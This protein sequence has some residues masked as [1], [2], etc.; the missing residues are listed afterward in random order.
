M[1]RYPIRRTAGPRISG[2]VTALGLLLGSLGGIP[3]AAQQV[4]RS[5]EPGSD[6]GSGRPPALA[7]VP[8][9]AGPRVV[10]WWEAAA[11]VGGVGA[12]MT[13]DR[14]VAHDA[15]EHPTAAA[16]DVADAFRQAGNIKVYA[17]VTLGTLGAGLLAHDQGISRTG[18]QLAASGAVAAASVELLKEATGRS[19]PDAGDGAYEFRP[20][21]GG[22]SF[23]SGHSAAAFALA[24]TIGDASHSIWVQAGLYAVATGTAWSRVYDERHWP[25]DVVLGA[26]L[27][28][29]SAKLVN[30]HWRIFHLRPPSFLVSPRAAG[31]QLAI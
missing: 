2:W 8:A 28:V 31:L 20:F 5:L 15:R 30:G 6:S 22:E 29:T 10:R 24:T 3:A 17:A 26:A 4:D 27:G 25:S 14:H 9:A 23:P 7:A 19:R 12:L 11:V 18:A 21:H 1:A 16:G 13:D